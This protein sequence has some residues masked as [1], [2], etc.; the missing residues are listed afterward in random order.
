[1]TDKERQRLTV[2]TGMLSND[3][4]AIIKY[5]CYTQNFENVPIQNSHSAM[6]AYSTEISMRFIYTLKVFVML[7][8]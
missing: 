4:C 2:E 8:Q 5:E 6:K 3:I 7:A 1:M